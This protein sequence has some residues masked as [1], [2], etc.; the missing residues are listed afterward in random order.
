MALNKFYLRPVADISLQHALYPEDSTTGY[1]LINE[2]VYDEEATYIYHNVLADAEEET[3]VSTFSL[4]GNIPSNYTPVA[5]WLSAKFIAPSYD[6]DYSVKVFFN[7]ILQGELYCPHTSFNLTLSPENVSIFRLNLEKPLKEYIKQNGYTETLPVT[8]EITTHHAANTGNKTSDYQ[9]KIG[10]VYIEIEYTDY[11]Q[12]YIKYG[13]EWAKPVTAYKKNNGQWEEL[14]EDDF[15]DNIQNNTFLKNENSNNYPMLKAGNSWNKPFQENYGYFRI[16]IVD[17][18]SPEGDEIDSWA[19]DV[20]ESGDIMCYTKNIEVVKYNDESD[21][22]TLQKLIIAG[23]GSG[24]IY[25]NPNSS[26]AFTEPRDISFNTLSLSAFTTGIVGMELLKTYQNTNID[27]MFKNSYFDSTY[28]DPTDPSPSYNLDLGAWNVKELNYTFINSVCIT[29]LTLPSQLEVIN[30]ALHGVAAETLHIPYTVNRIEYDDLGFAN[31]I[32]YITVSSD[33]LYFYKENGCF[34]N[35]DTKDIMHIGVDFTEIPNDVVSIGYGALCDVSTI[36]SI[37]I[38][39]NITYLGDICLSHSDLKNIIMLS[40]TPPEMHE[41]GAFGTSSAMSKTFA[42]TVP[43][44]YGETYKT[45]SVWSTYA[46][47]IIEEGIIVFVI[48]STRY[49]AE[50]GMT[51]AEWVESDYNTSS[52]K[53]DSTS[54]YIVLPGTT[55]DEYV[56]Y[57]SVR[58]VSSDVIIS[59]ATYTRTR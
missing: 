12:S 26:Y 33:N 23:N 9:M 54:D 43:T 14:I 3:L 25:L 27:G 20:D 51:W 40:S 59:K 21:V 50:E 57:D 38:P 6:S 34:I 11:N 31:A 32:K 29:G 28:V 36:T 48:E 37:T 30:N 41:D 49:Q 56:T 2:E 55:Y 7:N 17:S 52:Y 39:T 5:S 47:Y 4:G 10:Q 53:K 8:I 16:E 15:L 45:A 1:N 19:A 22:K 44:G 46:D 58:V 18:Y 35:K 24:G 13:T 42:I